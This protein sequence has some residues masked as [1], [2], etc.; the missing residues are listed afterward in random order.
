MART[1]REHEIWIALNGAM[2]ESVGFL[3]DCFAG[4]LPP[5]RIVAWDSLG[6]TASMYEA[7]RSRSLAAEQL[8]E[9]FL[10]QL[11]ADV[12]LTA[13]MFDGWGDSVVTSVRERSSALQ[14]GI[15]FDL[16]PLQMPATYLPDGRVAEWYMSKLEHLR[17]CDLLLGISH[18]TTEEGMQLLDRDATEVVNI[19]A[20][21]SEDFRP[22]EEQDNGSVSRRFG[23]LR[24][25][26]MYAGG[27]DSRKNLVRLIEAYA[28][29]PADLRS[30]HQL[31]F[32]GGIG[33][34]ER[35]AL[36]AARSAAGLAPGDLVFTGYV[37]DPD[38]VR[39][40]NTC[41]AYAF[42]STHEGFGLPALEAMSCG[43][44]VIA[45]NTT[46]LPEVVGLDEALFDPYDV[47]SITAHLV[48]ALTDREFRRRL[49]D[50]SV[51][52]IR[53][54]SWAKSARLAWSGIEQAVASPVH[55]ERGA[56]EIDTSA[57]VAILTTSGVEAESLRGVISGGCERV[58][59]FGDTGS[60]PFAQAAFPSGWKRHPLS[61]FD[62]A[63]FDE[64]I[65]LVRNTPA[66]ADLLLAL[67]DGD[68]TLVLEDA[69]ASQVYERLRSVAPGL[70]STMV[71]RACGFHALEW[72]FDTGF[73][74]AWLAAGSP[75][76]H[77]A[78]PGKSPPTRA[79]DSLIRR[80]AA[81]PGLDRWDAGDMARLASALASN[82][83]PKHAERT[84]YVDI[85][86]LAITDAGTG[87]QRVVRHILAELLANPPAGFRVE[88]VYVRMGDV[89]RY[90]RQFT[91]E[92][93][94]PDASVPADTPVD[95]RQGDIFLGLDLAAHLVPAMREHYL[96][97]RS[98]GV[99]I[100]FVVYD[101]LPLLRP[102]CF[103]EM[104]LPS[105][106]AWYEAIA[107][108]GDGIICISRTVAEE[109]THWLAQS[110]PERGRPLRIGWFH[111]G[112][113]M[114]S[115]PRTPHETALPYDDGGRP[116]FLMVGTIEP[117]KGHA[118]AIA[119]FEVL[120]RR[121]VDV[122][123]AIVGKAGWRVDRLV[124]SLR[125]H[126]ELH[127]RLFWFEQASDA[128]LVAMYRASSALLAASEGEGFG[129]PLIEAAQYGIPLLVR[130]LPVFKE[131][132]GDHASYF[133]GMAPSGLADAVVAWLETNREGGVRE[134][135][136]M[137]WLT[138]KESA[139]QLIDVSVGGQWLST[140]LPGVLR[141]FAASDYRVQSTT[142]ELSR[143]RRVTDQR[144]GILMGTV[145]VQVAAGHYRI[146][147]SGER[148]EVQ[149]EARID[150]EASD[151]AW[152]LASASLASGV[153]V[154]GTVDLMLEDDVPD[155]R[156]RVVVDA[157]AQLAVAGITF[158]PVT[159]GG[160]PINNPT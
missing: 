113:D 78:L 38:L 47:A 31:V 94:Y 129:L 62:S 101:L 153:G 76:W 130:D 144:R 90:A 102:D 22:L 98:R 56:A 109:F 132:A 60:S 135:A 9:A 25:F 66:T 17:R 85:S 110:M 150:V 61:T 33:A 126:P 54:F 36:T 53:K 100:Q 160:A 104:G 16:I 12:I 44:V 1:A 29:L 13:S 107:E 141:H 39:L 73:R 112:A 27:Y 41:A 157:Q 19:S 149:G 75:A 14:V 114:A 77:A 96:R 65:V 118:Q 125:A 50:H 131:V 32:V 83:P 133:S 120:W 147:V 34:P 97:M 82:Q 37:N 5:E 57:R 21:V 26:V 93:F 48:K 49:R 152:R 122:N 4:V 105:F 121:G 91:V 71:Y 99:E 124:A 3:R 11:D 35:E 67:D 88:P 15:L 128:H 139:A 59:V 95:F 116:T 81:V 2:P 146:D 7:N 117:R 6:Q 42:P 87:I 72:A 69:D 127:R 80:L 28:A 74:S 40:Y 92:R 45:S 106:R 156:I 159:P 46:S 24:P 155:L 145:P 151:G 111:L 103:D 140:W 63:S 52:Q 51:D 58:D 123:L 84:L 43:A 108:L 8:R 143:G 89:F 55:R 142:G 20:A 148:L 30:T 86:Q 79:A 23:I 138:W 115:R 18:F 158:T 154:I 70:A 137:P 68:A 134:S 64:V 136:A 10:E 119:A